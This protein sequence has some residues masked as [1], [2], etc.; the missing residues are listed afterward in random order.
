MG[1]IP[2][3][4]SWSCQNV[5]QISDFWNFLKLFA[6]VPPPRFFRMKNFSQ[7]TK[8]VVKVLGSRVSSLLLCMGFPTLHATPVRCPKRWHSAARW[9]PVTCW[10]CFQGEEKHKTRFS[11]QTSTE[12]YLVRLW[13]WWQGSWIIPELLFSFNYIV[14]NGEREKNPFFKKFSKL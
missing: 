11:E 7:K 14:H 10:W 1:A 2:L 5:V 6:R 3:L 13:T 9:L 8:F 12:N 4:T